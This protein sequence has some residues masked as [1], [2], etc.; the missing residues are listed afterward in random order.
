MQ[1]HARLSLSDK[2][3]KSLSGGPNESGERPLLGS[4]EFV[5]ILFNLVWRS[6]GRGK[7]TKDLGRRAVVY[8]EAKLDMGVDDFGFRGMMSPVGTCLYIC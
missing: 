1:L 8:F 6:R 4:N 5:H 2:V 3:T 7:D